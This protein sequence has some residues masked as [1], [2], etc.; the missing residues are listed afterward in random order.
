M[1]RNLKEQLRV[2]EARNDNEAFL[3]ARIDGGAGKK[4]VFLMNRFKCC[5]LAV[6]ECDRPESFPV[7]LKD[8]MEINPASWKE[9]MQKATFA[10]CRINDEPLKNGRPSPM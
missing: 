8:G 10:M 2:I 4:D 7:E 1:L 6:P 3:K 9:M 5:A